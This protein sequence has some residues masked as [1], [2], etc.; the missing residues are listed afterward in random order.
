[1]SDLLC[2]KRV[3]D[4]RLRDFVRETQNTTFAL[5]LGVPRSTISNWINVSTQ[6]VVSHEIFDLN[7]IQIRN[8]IL[9]L[10][11]RLRKVTTIMRLLF[12][13]IRIFSFQINYERL[14]EGK[15]KKKLLQVIELA[16]KV[17][18]LQA[19]LRILKLSSSRYH[20][21]TRAIENGCPLDDMPA[22]PKVHPNR[23]T[24][25]EIH[26]MHEMAI[27]DEFRHVSTSRLAV[28]AERLGKLFASPSTW[29]LYIR[30]RKWRRPR[31]RIHPAK[32]KVGLRCTSPNETWHIDTTVFRLLD[33]TKAYLQAII[34]NFSRR[35]L[36]WRLSSKLEPSASALLLVKAYKSKSSANSEPQS[37]M[38]D[39]GVE[40]INE[41]VMKLVSDGILKL[42]L[43]QTDLSFSNSMIEAFW[44]VMKHQWLFLNQLDS[45]TKLRRLVEFYVNQHNTVLPHSAFKGQ[46]PDE[47]YFLTGDDVPAQL[48]AAR[49][50]AR[51]A[52]ME[53]NRRLKCESCQA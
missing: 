13:V 37:V 51:K 18:P 28:L 53:E 20:S 48:E 9:N 21:W 4:H 30:M 14:P 44:R 6:D 40:N 1:M 8:R 50:K 25:N 39:A 16:C 49:V 32:P 47:M 42:I 34:D 19:V 26:I 5:N 12:L 43:A 33:G 7:D 11:H 41:A 22:C 45:L 29:N 3:Y 35:I 15:N 2:K 36:A 38:I 27:A 23:L 52:R 46:T 17:L 31:K 24:E 10:E